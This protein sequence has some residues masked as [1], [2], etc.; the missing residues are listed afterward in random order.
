MNSIKYI[1]LFLFVIVAKSLFAQNNLINVTG[2]IVEDISSEP[3]PFATVLIQDPE[4]NQNITG[5]TSDEE[6]SFILQVASSKFSVEVSF[7]GFE[8]MMISEFSIIGDKADLGVIRL[9]KLVPSW[10]RLS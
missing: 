7:I 5:T 1:I 4:T 3:V 2:K 10:T 6:G 9:K 8:N